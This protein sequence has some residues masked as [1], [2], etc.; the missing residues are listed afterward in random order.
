MYYNY[1]SHYNIIV[2]I[3]GDNIITYI[4]IIMIRNHNTY[5]YI[6]TREVRKGRFRGRGRHEEA[7]RNISFTT[8][9]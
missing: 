3:I 2:T 4:I 7:Q 6:H 8:T 5:D 9:L 1:I